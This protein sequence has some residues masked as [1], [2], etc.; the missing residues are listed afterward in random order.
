[1]DYERI[2]QRPAGSEEEIIDR[3]STALRKK[4]EEIIS[5]ILKKNAK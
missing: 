1:M 3:I 2:L 4:N 5:S